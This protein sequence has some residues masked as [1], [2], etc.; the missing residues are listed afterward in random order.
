M[1]L[2]GGRLSRSN[3][4]ISQIHGSSPGEKP[5]TQTS[6]R[7]LDRL[8]VAR[9]E[10]SDWDRLQ[11]VQLPLIRRWLGRV[12]GLGDESVDLG[13]E[14]LTVAFREILRFDRQREGSFRAWLRQVTVN[15]VRNFNKKR[16]RRPTTAL[17]PTDGFVERRFDPNGELAREWDREHDKHVV[18]KL[19]IIVQPDF[20]ATT[21][22]AFLRCPIDGAPAKRVAEELGLTENSDIAA[23]SHV[24]KRI[25]E[26]A[27]EPLGVNRSVEH[28]L[29]SETGPRI[30]LRGAFR[31]YCDA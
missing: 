29:H 11:E 27:G 1:W 16:R 26:E 21:W 31:C 20:S 25:R 5:V 19:L 23:K 6:V 8:Q 24:L 2:S 3:K 4:A 10:S 14:V 28:T 30:R 18:E 17:D 15:Q 12:P 9:P 13:Q 7:L 22:E